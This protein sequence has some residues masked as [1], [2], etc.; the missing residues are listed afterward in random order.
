MEDKI[1][2]GKVSIYCGIAKEM[3]PTDTADQIENLLE[4]LVDERK[5]ENKNLEKLEIEEADY[6]ALF[7]AVQIIRGL[8]E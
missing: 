7:N 8:A 2:R 5:Y 6:D 1:K 3:T 4:Y